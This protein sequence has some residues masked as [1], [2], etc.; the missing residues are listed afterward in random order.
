MHYGADTKAVSFLRS[1]FT[2][3]SQ[4]VD[5]KGTSS[6][7]TELFNMSCVQGSILG[8]QIFNTYVKDFEYVV[9]DANDEP[10]STIDMEYCDD[11][12]SCEI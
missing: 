10:E 3:R 9:G 11:E 12:T 6:N 4:Y 2:R 8:P 7:K 5:W 1:F